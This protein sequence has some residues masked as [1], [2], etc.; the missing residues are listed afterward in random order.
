MKEMNP[1]LPNDPLLVKLLGSANRVSSSHVIVKDFVGLEKTYPELL[2]DVL[3]TRDQLKSLLPASQFNERG[4]LRD[5][6]VFI[7]ALTRTG[8]EYVVAFFA[9]R[10][11]GGAYVPL[12]PRAGV[13]RQ[14]IVV[15][16]ANAACVLF[17]QRCTD[18]LEQLLDYVDKGKSLLRLPITFNS[19]AIAVSDVSIDEGLYLDPE[20]PGFVCMTSGTTG[21][22]KGVVIRRT[23]LTYHPINLTSGPLEEE[24][25]I[26]VNYNE[27]HWL[28]GA[29][30]T[31]ETVALGK[32]V[33]A[34]ECP[35]SSQDV[36][37]IFLKN[38][39]TYFIFNPALLHGM[40]DI[41]LGHEKLTEEKRVSFSTHFKSLSF[42]FCIGGL[43]DQPTVDF[44]EAVIGLPLQ[45]RYGASELAGVVTTGLTK[46]YGSVGKVDSDIEIKLSEGTYGRLLIK[47]PHRFLGYLGMEEATRAVFDEEGFYKTGD[48]AELRDGEVLLYGRERDDYIVWGDSRTSTQKVEHSLLRLPYVAA[49]CVVAVPVEESKQLC[50][51]VIRL[52]DVNENINLARIR[53]DLEGD[54]DVS[55]RPTVLRILDAEEELPDTATG[56]PIKRQV[57]EDFF[58]AGDCGRDFFSVH[59]PPPDVEFLG[60]S[61]LPGN[62]SA[63]A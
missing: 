54:L 13:E 5:E 52:K 20:G 36:L 45:N 63:T 9:V 47:S 21:Y 59:N 61:A 31:V 19:G 17:D 58:Y 7:T 30:N 46:T 27:S 18:E 8:Y 38:Q 1:R 23:C 42:F 33:F 28:G 44:W 37:D 2:A 12:D 22:S 25:G 57:I 29:K 35:A 39:V 34:L 15:S 26:A 4:L 53:A 16:R 48:I 14:A 62:Y 3:E 40:K 56:K 51:A 49:A 11:L 60:M 50:G 6:H 24:G 41:L 32:M 10:A 55:M 43:V